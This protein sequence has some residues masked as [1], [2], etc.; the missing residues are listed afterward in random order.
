MVPT[1][2]GL[3]CVRDREEQQKEGCSAKRGMSMGRQLRGDPQGPDRRSS[4]GHR[5]REGQRVSSFTASTQVP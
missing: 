1:E 2:P 5:R 3:P 4:G